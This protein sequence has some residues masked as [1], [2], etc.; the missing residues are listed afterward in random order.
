MCHVKL[1]TLNPIYAVIRI[2]QSYDHFMSSPQH[3][4][5]ALE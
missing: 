3:F 4:E 2:F 5:F 1:L